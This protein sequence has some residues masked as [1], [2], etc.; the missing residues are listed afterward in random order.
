LSIDRLQP[1]PDPAIGGRFG[2]P[3]GQARRPGLKAPGAW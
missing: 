3:G 1:R 2:E